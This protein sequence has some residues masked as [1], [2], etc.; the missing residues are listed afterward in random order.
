MVAADP[1]TGQSEMYEAIL[2]QLATARHR[3]W[4]T[5]GYFVP[6]PRTKEAL[7][8]AARRGVDVRLMLPGISDFWAPVAAGRSNY[9]DLLAAGV[10]IHEWR[11]AVMH[12]KT[13]V[14]DSSWSSIGSTNL[15]WRSFVHNWEADVVVRDP[16]FA[17]EMERRFVLDEQQAVAIDKRKWDERGPLERIKEA[18][19]RAWEYML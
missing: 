7:I 9:D 10:R 4:L 1:E 8:S 2:S 17:R 6:D 13:A 19:A 14:I 15:D 16:A 11:K 12:A 3:A 5:F 18:L